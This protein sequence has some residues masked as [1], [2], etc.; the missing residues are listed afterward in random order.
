MLNYSSTSLSAQT[1]TSALINLTSNYYTQLHTITF[2]VITSPSFSS[3][4]TKRQVRR[5]GKN[6]LWLKFGSA[7][8]FALQ[9]IALT[10]TDPTYIR[11]ALFLLTQLK[12]VTFCRVYVCVRRYFLFQVVNTLN[13][14][15]TVVLFNWRVFF[16][17]ST[18]TPVLVM[19]T[20]RGIGS[21][22]MRFC[23]ILFH[24][25]FLFVHV[26]VLGRKCP[27]FSGI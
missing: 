13:K 22:L 9:R 16:V 21:W 6:S 27:H 2:R 20:R 17:V 7:R 15:L 14:R 8:R 23:L 25:R 10:N 3:L 24:V 5:R 11:M 19:M 4:V 26:L 1:L 12:V 18:S